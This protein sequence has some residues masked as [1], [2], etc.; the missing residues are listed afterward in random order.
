MADALTKRTLGRTGIRVTAVGITN[1]PSAARIR[2]PGTGSDGLY[3]G[4][5]FTGD[6]TGRPS[7][8]TNC[9]IP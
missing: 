5:N 4:R 9:P 6:V 3:T 2:S 7:A 8:V 1:W